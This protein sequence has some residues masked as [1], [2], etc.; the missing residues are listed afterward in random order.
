MTELYVP[1]DEDTTV[2]EPTLTDL[3]ASL[4]RVELKIDALLEKVHDAQ[5]DLTRL[6]QT[7]RDQAGTQV[8]K[9]A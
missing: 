1:T 4:R 9:H 6:E 3:Q 7:L 8:V 5:G 2:S